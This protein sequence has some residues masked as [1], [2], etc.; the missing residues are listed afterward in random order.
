LVE[1]GNERLLCKDVGKRLSKGPDDRKTANHREKKK[2]LNNMITHLLE[3]RASQP[4]TVEECRV[5]PLG[6][7]PRLP[8]ADG[9]KMSAEDEVLFRY[10]CVGK[11]A[12]WISTKQFNRDVPWCLVSFLDCMV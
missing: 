12:V 4:M 2:L 5:M 8:P 11:P 3:P 1:R 9:W 10:F 6:I 7:P